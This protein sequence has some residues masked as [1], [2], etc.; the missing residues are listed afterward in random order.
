MP[1]KPGAV[2]IIEA[3]FTKL[4]KSYKLSVMIFSGVREKWLPL[5]TELLH[6]AEHKLGTFEVKLSKAAMLWRHTCCFAEIGAKKDCL[7][8]A[9]CS[10]TIHD[11]WVPVKVIQTS[12]NRILH[13]FEITNS[14]ALPSFIEKIA[15]AYA[16]TKTISPPKRLQRISNYNTIDEYLAQFDLSKRTFMQKIR[17]TIHCAAPE[18][19]EKISWQMPTFYQNGNLIHFCAAKKHVGIYPGAEVLDV[20]NDKLLNYITTKGSIHLPWDKPVPCSLLTDI[21]LFR[22]LQ[23]QQKKHPKF[24]N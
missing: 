21:T 11:E 8:I 22:V 18:A 10:N 24:I 5:Y 3:Q 9:F 4:F 12:K 1:L 23:M 19:L 16:L 6:L 17:E 15:A 20:F 2:I 13:Y 14:A 7:T